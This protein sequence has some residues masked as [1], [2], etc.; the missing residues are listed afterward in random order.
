[1]AE[2]QREEEGEPLPLRA[3][4]R[5]RMTVDDMV[6]SIVR[7]LVAQGEMVCDSVGLRDCVTEGVKEEV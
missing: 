3:P 1:M 6:D 7:V 5:D 2:A 4:E